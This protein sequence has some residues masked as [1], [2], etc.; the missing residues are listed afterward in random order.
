VA[1]PQGTVYLA[2]PDPRAPVDR[3]SASDD[4]QIQSTH[5]A[6]R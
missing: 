6:A 1:R 4:Y 2:W 3:R 5:L